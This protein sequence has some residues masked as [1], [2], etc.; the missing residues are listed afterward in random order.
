MLYLN[1]DSLYYKFDGE[2]VQIQPWGKNSLRIRATMNPQMPER[3]WALLEQPQQRHDDVKIQIEEKKAVIENGAVRAEISIFGHLIIY[4]K[5]KVILDEYLR[6]YAPD[7]EAPYNAPVFVKARE[8]KP[9][10]GADYE[11]TARFISL[12]RNEKIYGMG[13]YQQENLDLKGNELELAQRNSQ[14]SVPFFVSS[15]GYGMLWNNPSV[16][17]VTF[18][19]N[20]MSWYSASTD[21]LDYWITVGDTPKEIVRN[22]TDATG[23]VPVMPEWG[24]GFWQS[25][26][27]YRTQE[28]LLSIAREYKRRN[29]PLSV[30]II[31]YFH[32]VHEGE[33]NFDSRYWPDPEGMVK[34]LNGMGIQ[35]MV[36][37]WPT[38]QRESINYREMLEKGYLM[39]V[40]RGVRYTMVFRNPTIHCDVTNPEARKYFWNKVKENYF[41]KGIL[42]FWL[43]EAEPDLS[44][45]DFDNYRYQ[46]GTALQIGNSFCVDYARTFYEGLKESGIKEPLSLIR[47]AG[48][49][50]QRYGVLL[51]SGDIDST[52]ESMRRQLAAGLNA[53]MA[54]ISWWTCDIGG[55][56]HAD[57]TTEMWRQL[58]PRWF[59]WGAFCPVMRLHGVRMPELLPKIDSEGVMIEG[60]GSDNEIWSFGEE[61]YQ[62][63]KK[64]IQIR[65]NLHKYILQ[66][67]D[68]AHEMGDPIMR[69]L[70]YE[71]PDDANCYEAEQETTYMFGGEILVAPVLYQDTYQRKVYL[72][73]G[74]NWINVW[75]KDTFSGGAVY[76]VEAPLYSIPLFI[77]EDSDLLWAFQ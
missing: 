1:G 20:V 74:L 23:K 21:I 33:W 50:A 56:S 4:K 68:E 34:E 62:C 57:V 72:P 48:A 8:F 7:F 51:W 73:K 52:F 41:N 44:I 13:Q 38:V 9:R 15:L 31:D 35:L 3:L 70:F 28:E 76:E 63:C 10:I 71:F 6:D 53:G 5:D 47:C 69:P 54:G 42:S 26:M 14:A 17:R 60:T 67:M 2:T 11:V 45:Y 25:K 16:G 58:F 12:D 49:G 65:E 77:R 40:E 55:F 37:V 75:T 18:G 43:D 66:C 29:V 59:M 19:T 30:I 32:W 64:F 61:T 22:Y 24:L 39:K 46:K 36:S 27:R